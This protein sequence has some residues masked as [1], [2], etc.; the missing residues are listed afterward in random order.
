MEVRSV[1]CFHCTNYCMTAMTMLV[2]KRAV[3][4]NERGDVVFPRWNILM[5]VGE[6]KWMGM[7]PWQGLRAT[8]RFH[9]ITGFAMLVF[10]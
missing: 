9:S 10:K 7:G 2:Q 4:V 6:H 3:M 5:W 8:L 1:A